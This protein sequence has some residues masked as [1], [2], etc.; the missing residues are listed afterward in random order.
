MGDE[1]DEVTEVLR[2][3]RGPRACPATMAER[4]LDGAALPPTCERTSG[5]GRGGQ[6]DV[7]G[8]DL[9]PLVGGHEDQREPC[10]VSSGEWP[11][12]RLEQ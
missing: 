5:L 12:R 11:G 2:V 7:E 8:R 4:R 3:V 10:L 9:P 1:I 6:R